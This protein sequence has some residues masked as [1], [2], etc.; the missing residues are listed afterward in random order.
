[1][2]IAIVIARLNPQRG[3]AESWTAGLVRFLLARNHQVHVIAQG[4]DLDDPRIRFHRIVPVGISKAFKLRSFC[5]RAAE[6]A[7]T[8]AFDIV[9]DQGNGWFGNVFQA[10]AGTLAGNQNQSSISIRNPL[11]RLNRWLMSN[12][13]PRYRVTDEIA[14]RQ[15][16]P[17][18]QREWVAL[19]GMVRQEMIHYYGLPSD[20]IHVVYNG[21]EVNHFHPGLRDEL[22]EPLRRQLGIDENTTMFLSV[23]H[24]FRLKGVG[25]IVRA[26]GILARQRRDFVVVVVGGRRATYY[27]W[28]AFRKGCAPLIH[29]AGRTDDVRPYY[30]AA[31]AFVHPTYYDSCSLVV[32][33][34]LACGL[35]TITSRFNGAAELLT[36]GQEGY[37]LDSPRQTGMLAVLMERLTDPAR[38]R[39]MGPAARALAEQHTLEANHEGILDVYE[40][41]RRRSPL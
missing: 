5:L 20:R 27:R 10:H 41:A 37:L 32:L 17:S 11:H 16:D 4:C 25:E 14:R 21:T 24:H 23:A 15:F 7:A 19:S 35:P 29:L 40:A 28:L 39:D 36:D 38:R 9:H 2:K 6:V 12:I 34:A 13:Q 33:E 8:G 26:A 18:T 1:M 3:G 22:R 30:A 31:D